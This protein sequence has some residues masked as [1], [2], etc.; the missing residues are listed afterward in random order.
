MTYCQPKYF[1]LQVT[2]SVATFARPL[3][4]VKI[5]LLESYF[6]A[7]QLLLWYTSCL[8]AYCLIGQLIYK[9]GYLVF[10]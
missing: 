5:E 3:T 9:V 1:L 10:R 6:L 2:N 4:I 8:G 7:M